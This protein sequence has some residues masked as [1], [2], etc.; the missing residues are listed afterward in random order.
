MNNLSACLITLN[1][2]HNL[3][4]ALRSVEGIAD[5]I[6]VV[7]CGS[8]DSTQEVARH[9]GA[10]VFVHPWSD[11][12]N[13]KNF[14]AQAAA[15]PWIL[16]IDA[17]EEASPQLRTSLRAWKQ[18]TPEYEV[19]EIARRSFY[20][21]GWV[22]HSGWYP[23]RQRRLYRR[24]AARFSGMVHEALRFD[25]RI[26]RLQGDLFHYTINSIAE[27]HEKVERY[28]TLAARQMYAG[29]KRDWRTAYCLAAP[30]S[31]F[32]SYIL[33]AGFLDGRRG[34]IIAR[35]ACRTVRLKYH[36]LGQLLN[37]QAEEKNFQ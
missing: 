26:G 18:A 7:D 4:R 34:R 31:W 19:Y 32:R 11:Y 21:G 37:K 3:P 6:I 22:S 23:D 29:G 36:K 20:L 9:H 13:Q 28:S 8:S 10:N 30:W 14:A 25:G 1:E 35:M 12:S 17:D 2:E 5:E 24:D 33:R 16:S 27:H 15:H